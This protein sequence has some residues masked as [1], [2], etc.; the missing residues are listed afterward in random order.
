MLWNIQNI[1]LDAYMQDKKKRMF[2]LYF[3][4]NIL[5]WKNCIIIDFDILKQNLI[6]ACVVNS[7]TCVAT[8]M[9]LDNRNFVFH[10]RLPFSNLIREI[11][12]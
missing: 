11:N 5:Q 10:F 4:L 12:Q 1:F 9:L 6:T 3:N 8:K 2:I 7:R